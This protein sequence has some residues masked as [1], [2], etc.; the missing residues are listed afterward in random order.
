MSSHGTLGNSVTV[1]Q[2]TLNH[3][4]KVQ[5][6]VPQLCKAFRS[7]EL[8]KACLHLRRHSFFCATR[9]LQKAVESTNFVASVLMASRLD[10][11]TTRHA[12]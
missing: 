5:I 10:S 12:P 7:K 6:L 3:L 1:A 2:V 9:V 11:Q 8:R 4:V